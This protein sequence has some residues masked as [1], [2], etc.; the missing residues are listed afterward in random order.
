MQILPKGASDEAGI[1]FSLDHHVSAFRTGNA[2]L[3]FD[4]FT[5][6]DSLPSECEEFVVERYAFDTG[7]PSL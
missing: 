2:A 7:S 6:V 1:V 3:R 4:D 5:P